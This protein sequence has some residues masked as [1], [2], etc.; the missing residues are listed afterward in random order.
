[1]PPESVDETFV[2]ADKLLCH[3]LTVFGQAVLLGLKTEQTLLLR[4][5][6]SSGTK[7]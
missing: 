5:R 6:L 2:L 4:K 1:M 7:S 3:C